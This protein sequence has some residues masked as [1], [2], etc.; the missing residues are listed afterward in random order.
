MTRGIKFF[1]LTLLLISFNS[2][3]VAENKISF[4]DID[5]IYNSSTAGKKIN[6]KIQSD[7]KKINDEFS[8]YKK[9]VNDEKKTLITQKNILSQEE[10]Q[11]KSISLEKKVKE[12]NITIS[13]KRK[14]L[15]EYSNKAKISFYKQLTKVAQD[16][17]L[18]NSIE[19]IIKKK[20]ILIGKK[21]LDITQDVLNLFNENIKN[22]EIK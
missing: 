17:A 22:I 19:I 11:K 16:Y 9:A 7:L 13:N 1:F 2:Y 20:D 3:S 15:N 14:I 12:Y 18:T 5:F 4:I 10:F 6:K 8:S 21:T